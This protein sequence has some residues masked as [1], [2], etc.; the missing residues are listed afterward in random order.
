MNSVPM[1]LAIKC[2][3]PEMTGRFQFLLHAT[4]VVEN[5]VLISIE[6]GAYDYVLSGTNE[7][8]SLS[9]APVTE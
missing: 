2:T 4:L 8:P 7:Q 6:Q 1:T 9:S 3:N 5:G